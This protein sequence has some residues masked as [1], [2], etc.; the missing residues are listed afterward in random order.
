VLFGQR[1]AV[2]FF[3]IDRVQDDPRQR[4][5]QEGVTV[6][7]TGELLAVASPIGEEVDQDRFAIGGG[8]GEGGRQVVRGAR[9]GGSAQQT[10]RT[11]ERGQGEEL[12][13]G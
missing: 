6:R 10:G 2:A 9:R 3:G 4:P 11:G 8:A 1:R 12:A 5:L 7:R 13:H